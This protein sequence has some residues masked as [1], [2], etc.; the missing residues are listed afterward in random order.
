MKIG[1]CFPILLL[2][3]SA[4]HSCGKDQSV[5]SQTINE[6]TATESTNILVDSSIQF[7]KITGFGGINHPVWRPDMDSSEREK[8]FGI[9]DGQLGFSILRIHIDPN[10]NNWELELPTSQYANSL[11]AIVFASP[12]YAPTNLLDPN[13]RSRILP[14]KYDGYVNH[15]N[16]FNSFMKDNEVPLF[17]IS[18]Q[19]EPDIGEWTQWS[20]QELLN[21]M[22][23]NAQNI[24]NKVIAPE[25]F[26]FN[27][28]YSNPILNSQTAVDN[29]E[30]IGG[31]I[32]GGGLGEYTLANEKGKEIWMTEYLRNKDATD[33]WGQLSENVIWNETMEVLSTVHQS[34]INNWNAYLWWYIQR[35]YSFIGDGSQGTIKGKV[36]KR[37]YAFSHYSKFVRPGY[38]R[39]DTNFKVD[40]G[41]KATAYI[42]DGKVII[43]I[44]NPKLVKVKGIGISIGNEIPLNAELYTTSISQNIEKAELKAT[45]DELIFD[46][47]A[48]SIS[49]IVIQ[50]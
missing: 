21:F 20:S 3:G 27:R 14:E 1:L 33:S 40:I 17:A 19:N 26:N 43:V 24:E 45:N 41:L 42:G 11:G 7:Q 30:I 36:L 28:S 34:M 13:N 9:G 44:I 4:F 5:S 2:L 25:S 31:H 15:L 47:S 18:V 38:L 22:T 8:V 10:P 46:M 29:V 49:T 39:V 50:N 12:W 35:Y 16:E 37:G 6:P 23:S 32:Y 48:Q